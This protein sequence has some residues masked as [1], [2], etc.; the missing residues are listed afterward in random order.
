MKKKI[1]NKLRSRR[2]ASITYGLLLFLVCSVLCSVIIAAATTAAGRISRIAETDQKYYAVTSASEL[3]KGMFDGKS[4]KIKKVT[5]GGTQTYQGGRISSTAE[6]SNHTYKVDGTT[7]TIPLS[8]SQKFN[9]ILSDAGYKYLSLMESGGDSVESE[10]TLE[11]P[12]EW[13]NSKVK[14]TETV[15]KDG[16]VTLVVKNDVSDENYYLM[17]LEF[18]AN[19]SGPNA[20][21]TTNSL[22]TQQTGESYTV[23]ITKT[24]DTTLTWSLTGV[25]SGS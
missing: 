7:V 23:A 16:R 12:A 8:G 10:L 6:G 5:T 19:V 25:R 1:H 11:L 15:Y 9:S 4:A 3:L 21:E 17:V 22:G 20:Y 13:V 18:T 24:E 2:G 14:I